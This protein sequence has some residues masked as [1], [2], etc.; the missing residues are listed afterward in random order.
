MCVAPCV[1][2]RA[3]P[4]CVF[5]RSKVYSRT[6]VYSAI[7]PYTFYTIQ[8]ECTPSRAY[9]GLFTV[10]N[11]SS[12]LVCRVLASPLAVGEKP[13]KPKFRGLGPL[14]PKLGCCE[15]RWGWLASWMFISAPRPTPRTLW[16][17]SPRRPAPRARNRSR[18]GGPGARPL[19][20]SKA[21]AGSSAAGGPGPVVVPRDPARGRQGLAARP[22]PGAAARPVSS[23]S[24]RRGA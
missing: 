12:S 11:R 3:R 23:R 6:K 21:G 4:P 15:D 14:V 13:S 10:W 7:H 5:Q 2:E 8:T 24:E 16:R 20:G 22:L 9:E 19:P 18:D 17:L 1:G